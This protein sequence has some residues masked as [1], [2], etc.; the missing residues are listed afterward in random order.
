MAGKSS[1]FAND[2]LKLIFQGTP[3]AN[4][5]DNAASSPLTNL[6]L[7]LH[8]LDPGPTA[9]NGQS[10][11][12]IT[13]TGYGRIALV[14]SSTGWTVTGNSVSPT[15]QVQFG[16]KIGGAGGT[17]TG[18]D[19]NINGQDGGTR[20]F[21]GLQQR[22]APGGG[23]PLGIGGL[24]GE[25]N[26]GGPVGGSGWGS[27]CSSAGPGTGINAA[28]GGGSG[29]YLE[30]TIT[31]PAATYSYAVGAGGNGGAAGTSGL[32]G[33]GGNGGVIIIAAYY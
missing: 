23:N 18:G 27:G 21:T 15:S 17:A 11:N 32:A 30:K 26:G 13:Y 6:F 28:G 10:T 29:G 19:V 16:E 14:R 1:T 2:I 24:G 20:A 25:P 12:E 5:A 9:A 31:S 3:I 4:L 22:G 7:S 8:I 33:A